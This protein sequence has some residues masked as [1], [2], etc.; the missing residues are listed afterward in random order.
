M[1][2]GKAACFENKQTMVEFSP[3][4]KGSQQGQLQPRKHEKLPSPCIKSV[5]ASHAI[6]HHT[7]PRPS[8]LRDVP[9]KQVASMASLRHKSTRHT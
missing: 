9:E 6:M 8:S 1:R 5:Y 7:K 3:K 2:A 4:T